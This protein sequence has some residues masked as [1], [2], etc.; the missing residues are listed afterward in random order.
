MPSLQPGDLPGFPW[1]GP[2][3]GVGQ[4]RGLPTFGCAG[5]VCDLSRFLFCT[6]LRGAYISSEFGPFEQTSLSRVSQC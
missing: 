1:S 6:I 3:L 2:G 5:P 4:A